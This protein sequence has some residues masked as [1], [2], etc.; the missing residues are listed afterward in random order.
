MFKIQCDKNF[1]RI[2]Q[3][4]FNGLKIPAEITYFSN[5][6]SD[7]CILMDEFFPENF[8][9]TS[10]YVLINSDDTKLL[11]RVKDLKLKIVSC[12]LSTRSTAT[13]SS[14]SDDKKV[15]CLQRSLTDL[16]GNKIP[17]HELPIKL[18][19]ITIDDIS[20]IMFTV[21][22][23]LCGADASDLNKINI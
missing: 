14:I 22:A 8:I 20:V 12:G 4:S 15:V 9:P 11:N 21:S 17:Q 6:K 5:H 18:S 19:E 7:I 23:L 3:K 10:K 1:I 16:C 2:F 13:L